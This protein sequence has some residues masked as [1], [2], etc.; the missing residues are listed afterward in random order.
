[1]TTLMVKTKPFP[2]LTN[3]GRQPTKQTTLRTEING[4]IS[5]DNTMGEAA[6]NAEMLACFGKKHQ[7]FTFGIM[8]EIETSVPKSRGPHR[9]KRRTTY[10]W[11]CVSI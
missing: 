10:I 2:T 7:P 6:R 8:F 1:M 3:V 9:P 5:R 11:Q 4:T